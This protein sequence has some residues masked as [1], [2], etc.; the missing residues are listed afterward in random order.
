MYPS[1]FDEMLKIASISSE[2]KELTRVDDELEKISATRQVKELRKMY[3]RRD[4]SG[5]KRLAGRLHAA[6]VLKNTPAGTQANPSLVDLGRG[7]EGS[8][9]EVFGPHGVE[10]RKQFD[11][12]SR[13]YSR[14]LRED[15]AKLL[16]EARSHPNVVKLYGAHEA[17]NYAIHRMERVYG[18]PLDINKVNADI[19]LSDKLEVL[20][21]ELTNIAQKA[22]LAGHYDVISL[23]KRRPRFGGGMTI[24][25]DNILV[26]PNGN[27]KVIDLLPKAH[28]PD[29]RHPPDLGKNPVRP[30]L[31]K[32]FPRGLPPD[33]ATEN[34]RSTLKE[35]V[36]KLGPGSRQ[37]RKEVPGRK[38][39]VKV[40]TS[41]SPKP[42]PPFMRRVGPWAGIAALTGAGLLAAIRHTKKKK[43][44]K[45]THV[46]DNSTE[47]SY[48]KTK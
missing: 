36:S 35:L 29:E 5:V 19:R 16:E 43:E 24:R 22:G 38:P 41:A 8:A 47:V 7:A 31:E 45:V 48:L 33:E 4:I 1:F 25:T 37:P 18:R 15:K 34:A 14:E 10:V 44:R 3:L 6:G 12:K 30:G 42:L 46:P 13:F 39:L 20:E 9:I 23:P 27:L 26:E 11:P 17:P 40:P 21:S 32:Y 2:M 28:L